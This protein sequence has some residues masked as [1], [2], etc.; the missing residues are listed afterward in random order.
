MVWRQLYTRRNVS[1]THL[2]L[3]VA[4]RMYFSSLIMSLSSAGDTRIPL[5]AN[6][7]DSSNKL[8]Q[9]SLP[10]RWWA[11]QYPATSPGIATAKEPMVWKNA[12]EFLCNRSY[13]HQHMGFDVYTTLYRAF[14]PTRN[15]ARPSTVVLWLYIYEFTEITSSRQLS[16]LDIDRGV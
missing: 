13:F 16:N 7:M 8:A 3:N 15:T 14:R 12:R 11:S 5:S 1:Y 2:R 6:S 4:F 9:G 10:K